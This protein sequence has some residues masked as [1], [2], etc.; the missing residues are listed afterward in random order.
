MTAL[1]CFALGFPVGGRSHRRPY[2]LHGLSSAGTGPYFIEWD[3]GH[4]VYGED[5]D[6]APFDTDGVL[7]SGPARVYHPIRIA[8]FALHRFD[9]WYATRNA[10][11]RRDFLAQATWLRDRQRI[12]GIAGLYRFDFPWKKYGASAGWCSAMAQGEAISVLLRAHGLDKSAGYGDAAERAS[13]PFFADIKDGGVVWR[14]GANIF[15]EEIANEHAAHVLN[16]CIFALWGIWELWKRTGDAGLEQIVEACVDT[17]RRWL[18]RFD[19]GWWTRYSLLLSAAGQP[20]IATLKYH[21]FHIAQMH[22]L[23]AMFSEPKFE[24]AAR[25]WTSYVEQPN[26]R[27]RV[28]AATLRSLPE[29]LS[30]RDTIF[31]GAHT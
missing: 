14:D 23:A 15:L 3:P 8:Q 30:R 10:A 31:G 16:G 26:C 6:G 2:S 28:R 27:S 21:Q 29:R 24:E 7:L 4:G 5:W 17:L 20:H 25:R 1:R 18:P 13:Q 12:D 11:A 9:L 19:T 22:V